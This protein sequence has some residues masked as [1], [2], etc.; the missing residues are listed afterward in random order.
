VKEI[1]V[2]AILGRFAGNRRQAFMYCIEMTIQYPKLSK[3]YQ[4]YA[5][6]IEGHQG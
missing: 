3:E 4:E 1:Q 5:D 6:A 2:K